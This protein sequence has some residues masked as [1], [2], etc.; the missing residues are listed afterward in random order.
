MHDHHVSV[1]DI[2]LQT[3]QTRVEL[4]LLEHS[5]VAIRF[6]YSKGLLHCS[7]EFIVVDLTCSHYVDVLSHVI[8]VMVIL[9]HTFRDGLHVA[10]VS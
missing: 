9:D 1:V 2:C 8:F 3:T 4:R 7:Y 10:D 6:R 5:R